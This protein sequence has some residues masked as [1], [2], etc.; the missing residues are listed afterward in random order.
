MF[1]HKLHYLGPAIVA[2]K[3]RPVRILFRNLL[4]TGMRAG[5][6]SSRSTPP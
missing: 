2:Q 3:D 1:A 4:P 6:C 5:T